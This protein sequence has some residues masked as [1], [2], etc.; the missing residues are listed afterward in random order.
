MKSRAFVIGALLTFCSACR[1]DA[2]GDDS[3]FSGP[4]ITT[5]TTAE[6]GD[7]TT[8]SPSTD[9]TP[10]SG[11]TE[12]GESSTTDDE[13]ICDMQEF[14][15]EAIP[16]N[17]MLVLDKSGSMVQQEWDADNDPGTPDETRWRSLHQVVEFVVTTFENEINFG[18]NLFPSE[19]AA[20]QLGAAACPVRNNP[21]VPVQSMNAEN[22][23]AAIPPANEVDGIEG[24]T[25]ATAGIQAALDHLLTLDPGVDRFMILITDGAANCGE[26]ADTSMCPGLGCGLMEEYDDQLPIVVETAFAEHSV[27]TFVVGIDIQNAL[28]GE[29]PMDG[30]TEANTYVELNAVA[31]AGGRPRAG[32]EKFFNTVNEVELM[33]ALQSIAGQ[34]VSCTIP[35]TEA[36]EHPNFVEIEI[37]GMQIPRVQ[38]CATENGWVFTNPQGPYEAI[39]LCGTACDLLAEV[40]ELDAIFE[41][42]PAG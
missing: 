29:D 2:G 25:P 18:A 34:V 5:A 39:Q 13:L 7:E 33:D 41:C 10:T 23:L 4:G 28:V 37:G 14:V 32:T 31:E 3:T 1:N 16:P 42:P 11:A 6:T 35:F 36:P 20:T 21:E 24:A 26:N 38:D 9:T 17:V 12:S 22:I 8:G 27:P 40:R 15:L 30:Q 19:A